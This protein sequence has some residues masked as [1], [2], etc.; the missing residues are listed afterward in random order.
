[1]GN[2]SKYGFYCEV[3][4]STL[5]NR[6]MEFLLENQLSDLA[7]GD[8]AKEVIISRPKAYQIIEEFQNKGYIIKSRIIGKTQLY[9]LNKENFV[10]KIFMRNF[11]ECL[12]MVAEKYKDDGSGRLKESIS[13]KTSKMAHAKNC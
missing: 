9:K 4:G 7:V 2:N 6:V 10:V 13:T 1:M 11:K 3:Y 5:Q 12:R 8:V